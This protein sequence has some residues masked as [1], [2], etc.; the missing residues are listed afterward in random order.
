MIRA[1]SAKELTSANKFFRRRSLF[2]LKIM[3][4]PEDEPPKANFGKIRREYG[5]LHEQVDNA[6]GGLGRA[7][8][9]ELDEIMHQANE[10]LPNVSRPQGK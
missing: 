3:P 6:Q 4:G 8:K 7:S 9:E 10:L 2:D 5:D 1:S